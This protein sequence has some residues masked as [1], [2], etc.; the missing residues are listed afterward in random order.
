MKDE[1]VEGPCNRILARTS[2]PMGKFWAKLS[3]EDSVLQVAECVHTCRSVVKHTSVK[4]THLPPP[5]YMVVSSSYLTPSKGARESFLHYILNTYN[6]KRN[7]SRGI[8]HW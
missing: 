6:L 1:M 7:R 3:A 4:N 5:H 8:A 2:D